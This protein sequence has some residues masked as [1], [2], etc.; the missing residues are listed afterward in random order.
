M[1][2]YVGTAGDAWKALRGFVEE[3]YDFVPETHFGGRNYGWALRFRKSG[4]TLTALFPE[5]GTF[6]ALVVLGKKDA[7]KALAMLDDFSGE[8]RQTLT[9]T[10]QLHDGRWLW[11]R[12][13]KMEQVAD[14]QKLIACKRRPKKRS[15]DKPA[16]EDEQN[17][18]ILNSHH[19]HHS[20]FIIFLSSNSL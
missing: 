12:V 5:S 7:D 20:F 17:E 2:A 10:E 1:L 4:R 18:I 15:G 9:E 8:M 19:Y 16:F 13:T 3:Y 11:I 6:T 14:I